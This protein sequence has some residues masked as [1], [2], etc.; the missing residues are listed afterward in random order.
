M[1][2]IKFRFERRSVVHLSI[3][4]ELANIEGRERRRIDEMNKPGLIFLL[5]KMFSSSDFLQPIQELVGNIFNPLSGSQ[6]LILD[7]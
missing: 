5:M 7:I 2:A 3:G 4:E 6:G 1:L